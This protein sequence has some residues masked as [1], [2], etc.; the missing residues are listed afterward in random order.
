MLK[1][2]SAK[3]Y[4]NLTDTIESLL[5]RNNELEIFYKEVKGIIGGKMESDKKVA[6]IY[7]ATQKF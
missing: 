7:L 2:V 4:I 5:S 6:G 3:Q 1:N